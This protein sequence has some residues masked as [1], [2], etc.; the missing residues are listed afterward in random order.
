V[1]PAPGHAGGT[2][3]NALMAR[4][5]TSLSGIGGV[6]RPGIV[7]RLDREVSGVMV[8][9]K[10]DRA[11]VG[12]AGQFSVHTV[13]RVYEA[14]V[15][16][17]PGT[18]AGTVDRPI[19]RHP[20]DRQRM[21]IV[22]RGGKR[23]VTHW[24]LLEAAGLSAAR[25]EFRLETGRTHQIRVHATSLGHPILGDRLYGRGRDAR[26]PAAAGALGRIL[27][28]A[29]RLGFAHPVTGEKLAFDI[30]PPARFD[31]ILELLRR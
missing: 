4:C 15:W 24:R 6:L 20:V 22:A 23:A 13:D 8:A 29:R 17:V 7:H 26:L 14:V 1:H 21:A 27:L 16:G 25:L 18:A 11:H 19:G 12:L 9:A 2:L 10:H 28:H 3:V 5:G 31:A 30:P